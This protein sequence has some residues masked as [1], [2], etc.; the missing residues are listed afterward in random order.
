METKKERDPLEQG[1]LGQPVPLDPILTRYVFKR[2]HQ[3]VPT[4]QSNALTHTTLFTTSSH[5]PIITHKKIL[6]HQT[7]NLGSKLVL[8]FFSARSVYII[9]M[10]LYITN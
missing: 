4:T 5:S 10:L 8:Y 7:L 6:N 2:S 1:R 3:L 9:N